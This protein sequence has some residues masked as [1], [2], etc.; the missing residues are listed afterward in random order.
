M[1]WVALSSPYTSLLKNTSEGKSVR[2][3]YSLSC[4]SSMDRAKRKLLWT[5]KRSS[6]IGN[7]TNP[8]APRINVWIIRARHRL[9][10][11]VISIDRKGV[12]GNVYAWLATISYKK[13]QLSLALLKKKEKK[14][15]TL[16]AATS[17]N[18]L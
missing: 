9:L 7:V 8:I 14:A 15:M 4:F 10:S 13:N 6:F 12:N 3:W 18:Q 11:T 1:I 5:N 16:S 2:V 17:I